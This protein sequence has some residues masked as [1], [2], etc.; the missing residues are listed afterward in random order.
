MPVSVTSLRVSPFLP[1]EGPQAGAGLSPSLHHGP[2]VWR[3]SCPGKDS[4]H[5]EKLRMLPGQMLQGRA[6]RDPKEAVSP[7]HGHS[8]PHQTARRP[9]AGEWPW[10][11]GSAWPPSSWRSGESSFSEGELPPRPTSRALP[12]S[13][14]RVT[15]VGHPGAPT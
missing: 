2:Y 13:F 7:T 4:G 11:W 9:S 14:P 6:G 12:D 1:M 10:E 5:T 15:L 3:R 8:F